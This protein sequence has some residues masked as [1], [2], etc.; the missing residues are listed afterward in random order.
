MGNGI[1]VSTAKF[2]QSVISSSRNPKN[3]ATGESNL[4]T[5]SFFFTTEVPTVKQVDLRDVFKKAS[6][7]VCISMI[8]VPPECLS[9]TPSTPSAY[10]T[11][12]DERHIQVEYFSD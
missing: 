11:P 6:K 4:E 9:P 7:S 5:R 12:A 3:L 1:F 10:H 8:V 2:H